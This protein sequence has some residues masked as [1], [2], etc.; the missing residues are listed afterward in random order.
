MKTIRRNAHK[1]ISNIIENA[2]TMKVYTLSN[3][4]SPEKESAN[5]DYLRDL[6]TTFEAEIRHYEGTK[7]YKFRLHSNW[8]VE[9]EVA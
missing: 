6:V 3:G 5:R 7:T 9:V 1:M 4:F 8:W 2:Q